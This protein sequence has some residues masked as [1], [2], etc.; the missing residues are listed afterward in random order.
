MAPRRLKTQ[1]LNWGLKQ[2]EAYEKLL[3][4]R[5]KY[6]KTLGESLSREQHTGTA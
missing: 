1:L 2:Q 4:L 5:D 3:Q 6:A